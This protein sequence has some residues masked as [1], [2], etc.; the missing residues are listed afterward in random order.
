MIRYGLLKIHLQNVKSATSQF[1]I[2][3]HKSFVVWWCGKFYASCR[4]QSSKISDRTWKRNCIFELVHH[5]QVTSAA[6]SSGSN[7]PSSKWDSALWY[8]PPNTGK[9]P[10]PPEHGDDSSVC[11]SSTPRLTEWLHSS[12]RVHPFSNKNKRLEIQNNIKSPNIAVL[13]NKICP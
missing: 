13:E 10:I 3:E 4:S 9:P 2:Q 6:P 12:R 7:P 1:L 5:I 11:G 8:P